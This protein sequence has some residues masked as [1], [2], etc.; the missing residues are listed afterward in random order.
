[1]LTLLMGSIKRFNDRKLIFS[2]ATWI[3]IKNKKCYNIVFV[4]FVNTLNIGMPKIY[5]YSKPNTAQN[6]LTSR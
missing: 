5:F 3:I 2:A 4:H 1:M 6:R